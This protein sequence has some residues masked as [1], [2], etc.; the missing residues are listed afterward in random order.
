LIR[1]HHQGCHRL[2]Q[3][4]GGGEID[5]CG[6]VFRGFAVGGGGDKPSIALGK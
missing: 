5:G 3:I 2:N 6:K 1:Q 4:R